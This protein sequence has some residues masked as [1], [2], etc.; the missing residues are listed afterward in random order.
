LLFVYEKIFLNLIKNQIFD[1]GTKALFGFGQ[2][3]G[4]LQNMQNMFSGFGK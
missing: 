3:A 4:Q 2:Q 1:S